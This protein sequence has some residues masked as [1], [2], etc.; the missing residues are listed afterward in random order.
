[1]IPRLHKFLF[2]VLTLSAVEKLLDA[3][4][5]WTI[6]E[7]V[8]HFYFRL[9]MCKLRLIKASAF[10]RQSS[11]IDLSRHMAYIESTTV[12]AVEVITVE[13]LQTFVERDDKVVTKKCQ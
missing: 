9:F 5:N 3:I 12:E 11:S 8:D 4:F 2:A 13:Y 6:V 7:Q 10:P 1:M